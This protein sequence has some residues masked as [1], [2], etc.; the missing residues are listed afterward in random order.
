M[1]LGHVKSFNEVSL[2]LLIC[3]SINSCKKCQGYSL[4]EADGEQTVREETSE[5]YPCVAFR[6]YNNFL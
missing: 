6:E 4:A 5:I 1:N 2:L 3:L